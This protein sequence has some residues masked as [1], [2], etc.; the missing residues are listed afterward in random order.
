[1][2]SFT[3]LFLSFVFAVCGVFAAPIPIADVLAVRGT[4]Y[5]GT[6]T[7]YYP[8]MGAC[9]WVRVSEFTMTATDR[10]PILY[11]L[12]L[13]QQNNKS[14]DLIVAVS[15]KIWSNNAHC[16]KV[17]TRRV[18]DL[19]SWTASHDSLSENLYYQWQEDSCCHCCRRMPGML[20][21]ELR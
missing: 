3:I 9:G 7:Y 18:R 11:S 1:M 12:T 8:G 21:G 2:Q 19:F 17:D 13:L 10:L 20:N 14:T 16:G 4:T 6:G 15:Q 5:S